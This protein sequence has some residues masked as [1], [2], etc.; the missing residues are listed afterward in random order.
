[1][2][3]RADW[4]AARG[5][6]APAAPTIHQ[7]HVSVMDTL[8]PQV[9]EVSAEDITARFKTTTLTKIEGEQTYNEMDDIRDELYRNAMAIKSPFGGG[10]HGHL[11]MIMKDVLYQ[12][13]A[14]SAWTVATTSQSYPTFH[15]MKNDKYRDTWSTSLANEIGRLAQ[16][17]RDIPGTNTIPSFERLRSQKISSEIS[18]TVGSLGLTGRKRVSPI[19]QDSPW[20]GTE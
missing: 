9:P 16:G 13:E 14:G 7:V 6:T 1:M 4:V 2:D 17:I 20:V 11:G 19:V 15:L 3:D 8:I 18:H 10:K 5:E 12:T